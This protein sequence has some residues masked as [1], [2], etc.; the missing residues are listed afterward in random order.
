M[1]QRFAPAVRV[2]HG[3][4]AHLERR[5]LT[6][7]AARLPRRVNPDHLTALAAAAAAGA[8]LG[9]VLARGWPP[10][11]HLVN[12]CLLLHWLGDS[13]DGTLARVRD[14]QRPRYGFYVDHVLDSA[15]AVMLLL[16]IAAS[17]LMSPIVALALLAAYLLMSVETYLASYCVG[18][19]RLSF[20]GVGPT[21][22]RILLA[23]GNVAALSHPIV[24][25][26]GRAWLLFDV[27]A[28]V[29]IPALIIA[30]LTGAVR[31]GRALYRAEPRPS[32]RS[33]RCAPPA[34]SCGA[35]R[36][37]APAAAGRG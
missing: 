14:E 7:M 33:C 25:I 20:L 24:E 3:V 31:H 26:G 37:P 11:L 16:G 27:G 36:Q 18:A 32:A 8:A 15:S 17:G 19:F 34:P 23:A 28:A 2:M 21:E 1:L 35:P 12:A 5:A 30:F 9:Y 6:W 22:L 10:A 4:T 29:A 13:L